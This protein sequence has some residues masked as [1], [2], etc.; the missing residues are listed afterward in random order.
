MVVPA[1]DPLVLNLNG[2]AFF[3]RSPD[4]GRHARPPVDPL[5]GAGARLCVEACMIVA[6]DT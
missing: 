4:V 5:R 3:H 1:V 2:A 6:R